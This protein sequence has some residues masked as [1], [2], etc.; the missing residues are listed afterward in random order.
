MIPMMKR[1]EFIMGDKPMTEVIRKDKTSSLRCRP[2]RSALQA[3]AGGRYQT[4]VHVPLIRGGLGNLAAAECLA[5]LPPPAFCGCHYW[6]RVSQHN[7]RFYA[8]LTAL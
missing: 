2:V 3:R 8:H 1:R 5:L 7:R 4:H 6:P